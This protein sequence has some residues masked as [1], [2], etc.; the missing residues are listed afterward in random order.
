MVYV[1]NFNNTSETLFDLWFEDFYWE[2]IV[3]E[4]EL[5]YILLLN[6]YTYIE[7]Y[8]LLVIKQVHQDNE[9]LYWINTWNSIII[10]VVFYIFWIT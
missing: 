7:E 3:D 8:L 9:F 1:F 5:E 4:S 6:K 2:N 10:A